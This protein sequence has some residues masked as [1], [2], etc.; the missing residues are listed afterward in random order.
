M[1][2]QTHRWILAA[3]MVCVVL[4]STP[5]RG[6]E[7]TPDQTLQYV[8]SFCLNKKEKDSS[9]QATQ[10]S[11]SKFSLTNLATLYLVSA[12][13]GGWYLLSSD[14]RAIAVLA[15]SDSGI[16]DTQDMPD[17][18]KWL[19]SKYEREI[20][21]LQ[22]QD[23]IT[24]MDDSWKKFLAPQAIKKTS[25]APTSSGVDSVVLRRVEEVSWGQS[26]NNSGDCFPSY[27]M[28]CPTFHDASC[29]H[30]L[31]GC[32]VVAMAQIMW[33]WGWPHAAYVPNSISSSGTPSTVLHQQVYDWGNMPTEIVSSTPTYQA[34]QIATLL[35]DC[36]YWSDPSYSASGTGVSLH[37]A[38][39]TLQNHFD[40]TGIL[41]KSNLSQSRWITILKQNID[42]GTPVLFAG[43]KKDT[44]AGH[45]FVIYG[46][47]NLDDK[48]KINW[49]WSHFA[50]GWFHLSA[51]NPSS[52]SSYSEDFEALVGITPNYLCTD[53]SQRISP[54]T[55]TV[56]TR[57]G[58]ITLSN[59]I[60]SSKD[61][62]YISGNMIRLSSGF[63][64]SNGS[65]VQLIIKPIP[66]E[67][68]ASLLNIED[69]NEDE[70]PIQEML[71]PQRKNVGTASQHSVKKS[72]V[73]GVLVITLEDN[74]SYNILGERIIK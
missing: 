53:L 56:Y 69:I 11:V 47:R 21:Y 2:N 41:Y 8:R 38:L 54:V 52:S 42:N 46:Y 7:I 72:L 71:A 10:L 23:S 59:T 36:G 15:Y 1:Y 30:N 9:A 14:N 22:S 73:D 32:T 31:V 26:K 16:L 25:T 74:V 66:C 64:A 18:M 68:T 4:C 40:Y 6:H 48:F 61:V 50:K 5:L 39:T 20:A 19:F 63:H 33:Y 29:G 51:L 13:K 24:E 28:L 60:S 55:N 37:D 27:N 65:K 49:G 44:K 67:N 45:A 34:N 17:A 43:Y 35:R 3:F 70:D 57:G 62:T 58:N 12:E